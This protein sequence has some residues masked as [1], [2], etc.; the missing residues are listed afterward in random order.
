M[1]SQHDEPTFTSADDDLA[2]YAVT[3]TGL[4]PEDSALPD[5]LADFLPPGESPEGDAR[6]EL[7]HLD[8]A[9]EN[10]GFRERLAKEAAR[11]QLVMSTNYWFCV[12]FGTQEQAETF[13]RAM[14][15]KR[16]GGRYLDGRVLAAQQGIDLPDDPTWPTVR[17]AGTWASRAHTVEQNRAI[18]PEEGEN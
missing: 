6:A 16:H 14:D 10:A 12:C 11:M 7:D 8:A 9:M 1:T 2:S 4:A 3:D 17:P 5:P 15:W 18:D 13:L